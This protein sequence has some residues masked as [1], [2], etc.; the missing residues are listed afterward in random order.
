M[1]LSEY[2]QNCRKDL[3]EFDLLHKMAVPS[4]YLN[5]IYQGHSVKDDDMLLPKRFIRFNYPAN[6]IQM[7]SACLHY[8]DAKI[9][10]GRDKEKCQ[11]SMDWKSWLVECLLVRKKQRQMAQKY[12][13]S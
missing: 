8:N 10:K 6:R 5:I 4:G 11:R 7:S 9:Y 1:K 12:L 3:F 2:G 13:F